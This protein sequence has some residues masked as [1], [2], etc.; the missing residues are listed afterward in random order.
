MAHR[1]SDRLILLGGGESPLQGEA[2]GGKGSV[3]GKHE[4]HSTE[5]YGPLC[6]EWSDQS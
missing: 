2:A 1:Q 3:L 4:P 6:N 5:G